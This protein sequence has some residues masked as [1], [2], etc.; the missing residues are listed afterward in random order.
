MKRLFMLSNV[1]LND[2]LFDRVVLTFIVLLL[3]TSFAYADVIKIKGGGTIE[4]ILQE[5]AGDKVI[6]EIKF[7]HMTIN[8]D[9]IEFIQRASEIENNTLREKWEKEKKAKSSRESH[10]KDIVKTGVSKTS[11]APSASSKPQTYKK[12][13]AVQYPKQAPMDRPLLIRCDDNIHSYAAFLPPDYEKRKCPVLF[14]FDPGADGALAVRKFAFAAEKYGWIVVGSLD[15]R[16][17]PWEPILKAQAAMLKDVKKRYN[18]DQQRFYATGFSGGARAAYNIAYTNPSNFKGIIACS[19][20]VCR[21]CQLTIST[22]IAV[23]HCVGKTDYAA[24]DEIKKMHA[25]LKGKGAVSYINIFDGGHSWPPD[26]VL[27][28]AVGWLAS[29]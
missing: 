12:D 19:A 22:K 15:A 3:L 18:V 8:K 21:R 13:K 16:N 29:R 2:R 25:E 23:Y 20:G 27:R 9:E 6:V 26:N 7:G 14:C 11:S 5:E 4:G 24:L 17:G 28:E 10:D 1:L